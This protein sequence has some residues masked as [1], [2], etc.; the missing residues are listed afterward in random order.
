MITRFISFGNEKFQNSRK[1]ILDEAINIGVFDEH[2][3]ENETICNE[4]GFKKV[5]E[6]NT[7][8]NA[9]KNIDKT[10]FLIRENTKENRRYYFNLYCFNRSKVNFVDIFFFIYQLSNSENIFFKKIFQIIYFVRVKKFLFNLFE[11]F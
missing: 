11:V 7:G 1:R 4:S 8:V 6:Y 3:I 10:Y 2:C 9:L 5:I